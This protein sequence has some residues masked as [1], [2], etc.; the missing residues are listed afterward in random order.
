MINNFDGDWVSGKKSL[1]EYCKLDTEAMVHILHK[2][3]SS[4]WNSSWHLLS[5]KKYNTPPIASSLVESMRSIGYSIESAIADLID[6]S[7]TAESN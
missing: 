3:Q 5:M 6:N 4:L 7:I 1:R 2:L